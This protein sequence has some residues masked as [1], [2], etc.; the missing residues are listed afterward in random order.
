MLIG[1]DP[2]V[3]TGI[4]VWCR[5]QRRLTDVGSSTAV[6]AEARILALVAAGAQVEVWVEDARQRR[7]FGATGPERAQGAGAIKRESGRWQEW[8]EHH[9]IQHT[10]LH[11]ARGATKLPA[12]TFARTTG[13]PGRTNEHARDAAMLVWGA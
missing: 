9:G 2:G 7:Y 11:P 13:W 12:A 8:L 6:A 3:I 1:I 5:D 10:M 4:A